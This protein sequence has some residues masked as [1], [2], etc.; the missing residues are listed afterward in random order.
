MPNF[1]TKFFIVD[2]LSNFKVAELEHKLEPSDYD[3]G[4]QLSFLSYMFNESLEFYFIYIKILK[5]LK[6]I[7]SRT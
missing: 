1:I 5:I 6:Y 3:V 2:F 4:M 7:G